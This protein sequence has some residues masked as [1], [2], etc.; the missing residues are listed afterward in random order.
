[1]RVR[2]YRGF[3]RVASVLCGVLLL[4]F[5]LMIFRKALAEAYI[6][7]MLRSLL[8]VASSVKV[9]DLGLKGAKLTL[10]LEPCGLVLTDIRIQWS[11]GFGFVSGEIR[12]DQ[13]G[14]LVQCRDIRIERYSLHLLGIKRRGRSSIE[15]RGFAGRVISGGLAFSRMALGADVKPGLVNLK[16]EA[17]DTGKKR[18]WAAFR[19]NLSEQRSRYEI[20]GDGGADFPVLSAAGQLGVSA[21][22]SF[23]HVKILAKEIRLQW[24]QSSVRRFVGAENIVSIDFRREPRGLKLLTQVSRI[25]GEYFRVIVPLRLQL[26][27]SPR[28]PE[29]FL[30]KANADSNDRKAVIIEGRGDFSGLSAQSLTID[31]EGSFRSGGSLRAHL[32]GLKYRDP[33]AVASYGLREL[34]LELALKEK[35]FTGTIRG[36]GL[37]D[38]SKEPF[39]N[40]LAFKI[41]GKGEYP[42]LKLSGWIENRKESP[43]FTWHGNA[44][45]KKT[46]G[47]IQLHREFD[48]AK[49]ELDRSGISDYF[50]ESFKSKS[51]KLILDGAL[52]WNRSGVRSSKASLELRQLGFEME[53]VP[54]TQLDG[55]VELTSVFPPR[56]KPAQK[57]RV[58]AIGNLIP[59][60]NTELVL[61][62]GKD[63]QIK[64]ESLCSQWADGKVCASPFAIDFSPFGFETNVQVQNVDIGRVLSAS[65]SKTLQG[66]G[67]LVGQFPVIFR[68]GF[69]AIK[70][71][72]LTNGKTTGWIQYQDV[73]LTGVDKEI[74][75]MDQFEDLMSRGQQALVLKALDNF[76]FNSLAVDINRS[77][78]DGLSAKIQLSGY[79][80]DLGKGI[81]FQFNIA[82]SG[83]LESAVKQSL[84]RGLMEPEAFA[85][86]WEKLFK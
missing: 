76:F 11:L 79:N 4:L 40:P 32:L 85:D 49:Q 44:D 37:T 27:T 68:N 15:F 72:V 82:V 64:V 35:A 10:R 63:G 67:K 60:E 17:W 24:H 22:S 20:K 75:D 36:D 57:V 14:D 18:L 12:F 41:T 43:I 13:Q 45:L 66:R 73:M 50:E 65:E 23:S 39:F 78:E 84:L 58:Q 74:V 56:M 16:F 28:L 3:R 5:A 69:L 52:V 33:S 80:P 46:T 47:R 30:L 8:P 9:Q 19:G 34:A 6:N 83:Q 25:E 86:K 71:G 48:F 54:F 55:M 21:D 31:G 51:G 53:G 61:E 1:M 62:P 70:K 42:K 77:A 29:A 26:E 7:R 59:F 2:E 38:Q 81:P